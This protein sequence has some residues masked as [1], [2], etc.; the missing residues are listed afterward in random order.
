MRRSHAS[1]KRRGKYK[2]IFEKNIAEHLLARKLKVEYEADKFDYV[3][4]SSYTPDWK[5]RDKLYIESKGYFAPSDRRNLLAFKSQHPEIEILLLFAN[6]GNRLHKKSKTTYAE[7]ATMHE[8][9]H[10]DFFKNGIPNE[11]FQ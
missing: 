7:W 4:P 8:F 11:W 10:A 2:S 1:K 5:I 6:S 3:R 9:R